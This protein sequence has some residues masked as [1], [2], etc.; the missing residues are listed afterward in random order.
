MQRFQK[1]EIVEQE[2]IKLYNVLLNKIV[3]PENILLDVSQKTQV[4]K[5]E[6]ILAIGKS[7]LDIHENQAA[8]NCFK[9]ARAI[10]KLQN[11]HELVASAE[12]NIGLALFKS[13][14]YERSIAH[15]Q[16]AINHHL[17]CGNLECACLNHGNV[18][19]AYFR[20][21]DY[22]RAQENVSKVI[23]Y[24][25]QIGDEKAKAFW[26]ANLKNAISNSG[27]KKMALEYF[28]YTLEVEQKFANDVTSVK[29]LDIVDRL[30]ISIGESKLA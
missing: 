12:T 4:R 8:I 19:N 28:L 1:W 13:G 26:K 29:L 15:Y 2:I 10:G 7:Y 25:N 11:S 14:E 30:M 22:A 16:R 23:R 24:T 9:K 17:E 6:S 21:G 27:N 20:L 5:A 18:G 3:E